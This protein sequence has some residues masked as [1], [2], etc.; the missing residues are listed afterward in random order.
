MGR[1]IR[2]GILLL[3][4]LLGSFGSLVAQSSGPSSKS[5]WQE[6]WKQVV[7]TARVEAKVVVLGPPGAG[8]RRALTVGFQKSFPGIEVEYTGAT[9]SRTAP[10]LLAE[11]RSKKYLA[12]IYIS[13][14]GTII[15]SLLPAGALDPIGPALILP[16]VL[17]TSKWWQGRLEFAD[18]A[19][20]YDL[21]FTTNVRT[22]V[23]I[24]PQLVNK[25]EIRSYWDLLNPKWRGKIV[26]HD[27][28]VRGPGQGTAKFFLIQPTLGKEFIRRFFTEQKVTL[29]RNSRQILEWIARGEYLIAVS[30]SEL[31][32]TELKAKG[33]PIELLR[34]NQFKEGSNL[35][36]GFGTV[37]LINRAPHPATAK[38][39]LNWLL[40]KDG[41]T[42]WSKG[43]GY[44][45]RRIDV[46]R[47]Q[48]DPAVLP[49]DGKSYLSTYKEE[50][51]HYNEEVRAFIQT[52]LKR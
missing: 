20:K 37:A 28:A 16:E 33:L 26:M 46:P 22:H 2:L 29:S 6:E 3:I 9:G 51:F 13:G 48:F 5:G 14:T 8:A 41:Q 50:Y 52:I 10:R 12:D 1:C 27:P 45:S 4:M 47:D 35:N 21:V 24:N 39:Y 40:S 36:A 17:D 38:V 34:S 44:P 42:A 7:A 18:R 49:Q 23:A 19:E 30:P 15:R 32:T 11:R 31:H 43:S 25:D